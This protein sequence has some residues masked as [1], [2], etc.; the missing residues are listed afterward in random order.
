MVGN[1]VRIAF[2]FDA[3]TPAA[4]F[5][6]GD[7]VWMVFDTP[8][9]LAAPPS[10]ETLSSVA[11]NFEIVAAGQTKVVRMDLAVER[12]ATMG[13]EGRAWVLSLGDAVLNATEPMTLT[14]ERD[15]EGRYRMIADLQ[16]PGKVHVL[17]DPQ[18]G[19]TLRVVTVMPPARGLVRSMQFVDFDALRSAHGLVIKPRTDE[20]DVAID[21]KT[22]MISSK[23][24]LTMSAAEASRKL[25]AGNAPEFRQSYLDL[26]VWREDNPEQFTARKEKAMATAASAEGRQRDVARLDLAQLYLGNDLSYEALGVL[27]VLDK[28]LQSD[29]LR[30]KM[31]LVRAVA[32]TLASRSRDALAILNDG[33]FPEETDA[34]LWRA[35]A[36]VDAGDF[37]G[38]RLDA[39]AAGKAFR[40]LSVLDQDD[41][42][43]RRCVR[44][45]RPMTSRWRCGSWKRWTFP[46]W[47]RSRP[48]SSS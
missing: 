15:E 20:L 47:I 18:V 45:S 13:S 17:R 38:A 40:H 44:R 42:C 48:A 36:R 26:G 3:D 39:I 11:S 35:I 23:A 8:Q 28:E 14:R 27:D 16:R 19:D 6:R 32:D 21:D 22:A 7:T 34:L 5:R 2:P 25:D 29:D 1:T 9:A 12:L 37:R 43:S 30:K 4:V 31:H 33:T 24:G 46:N 10:S 41:S